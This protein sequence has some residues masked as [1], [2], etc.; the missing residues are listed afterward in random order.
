MKVKFPSKPLS[1]IASTCHCCNIHRTLEEFRCLPLKGYT[2]I[3]DGKHYRPA[4][5]IAILEQR[6]CPCKSTLSVWLD[7]DRNYVDDTDTDTNSSR[8]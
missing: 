5:K 1:G 7:S 6:D 4:G 8:D 2:D 3:S